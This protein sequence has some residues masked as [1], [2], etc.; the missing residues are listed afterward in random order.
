MADLAG[1]GSHLLYV[2][3]NR[4]G[5]GVGGEDEEPLFDSPCLTPQP[6]GGWRRVL[7]SL[8]KISQK[9]FQGRCSKSM[10]TWDG[11]LEPPGR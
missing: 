1:A 5:N 11:G 4:N 3:L 2:V 8:R 10:E 7:E 9:L 6:P